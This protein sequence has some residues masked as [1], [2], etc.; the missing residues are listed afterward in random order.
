M[1]E[2]PGEPLRG[3]V[4]DGPTVRSH[5]W[6]WS[7]V[8]PRRGGLPWIGIFLVVFGAL[9]LL[10]QFVPQLETAGSLLFL[11]LGIAFLVSW[12]VNGGTPSLYAG[13]LITALAA[14]DLLQAAGVRAGEGLGTF[15]LGV[16]FLAIAAVRAW[17][18]NG[19]GWQAMLGL[20]LVLIGATQMAIP[21]L[22][23]ILW[24]LLVLGAGVALLVGSMRR[25]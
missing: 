20:V 13:A 14:P 9:L 17:S 21:D 12:G 7:E 25:G 8:G 15:C 3:D 16:A 11:A 6:N 19:I 1:G 5:G 18:R 4:I 23:D 22:S 10:R 2:R 24:P